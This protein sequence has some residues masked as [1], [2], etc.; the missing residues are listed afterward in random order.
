MKTDDFVPKPVEPDVL[1]QKI[2]A[3]LDKEIRNI[4]SLRQWRNLSIYWLS[5]MKKASVKDAA[6]S[7]HRKGTPSI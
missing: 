3:L 2:N 1:V 6:G 5:T 4:F 7:F